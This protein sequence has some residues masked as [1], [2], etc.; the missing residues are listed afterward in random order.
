MSR[1][2]GFTLIEL[3]IVV[4]IIGI[5]AAIALP[6]YESYVGRAQIAEGLTFA[7]QLKSAIQSY[8][9]DAGAFPKDNQAA[10]L[11]PADKLLGNYVQEI[12]VEQ[13]AIHIRYGHYV[14][15][16]V[17]NKILSLRPIIVPDSPLSPMS[18]T[19]GYRQA[20]PGMTAVGEDRTDIDDGW[21]P[22]SCRAREL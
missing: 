2:T 9:Q 18:W 6:A 5:L 17:A 4:T 7:E 10:A 20:P 15:L 14:Q 11:P 8:Y 13:G 3:M 16:S 22:V 1:N 21:L 12:R 19:C